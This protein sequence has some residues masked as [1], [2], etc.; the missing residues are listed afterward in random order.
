MKAA[1]YAVQ[2]VGAAVKD[3]NEISAAWVRLVFGSSV[4]AWG[5]RPLEGLLKLM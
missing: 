4:S 3:E 5:A 1:H 2:A